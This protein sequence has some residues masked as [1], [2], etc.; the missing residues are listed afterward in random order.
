GAAAWALGQ[1]G[2]TETL[3]SLAAQLSVERESS[4]RLELQQAI[5][6]IKASGK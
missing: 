3:D 5:T 1:L 4:V 6:S 2:E